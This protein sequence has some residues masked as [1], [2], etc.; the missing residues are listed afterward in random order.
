[1]TAI[2]PHWRGREGGQFG[3]NLENNCAKN[4]LLYTSIHDLP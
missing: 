2:L 4:F 1:M 3:K